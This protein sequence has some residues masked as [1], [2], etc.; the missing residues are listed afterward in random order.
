[1]ARTP[2]LIS[3]A[4]DPDHDADA[5]ASPEK[6]NDPNKADNESLYLDDRTTIEG[7]E[8]ADDA[9]KWV[10]TYDKLT[11]EQKV[12]VY[13]KLSDED[14]TELK[15]ADPNEGKQKADEA[16]A[17]K[18]EYDE[19][20]TDEKRK[21]AYDKLDADQKK[22]AYAA[23][24]ETLRKKLGIEDPAAVKPGE[25]QD[26]KLPDGVEMDKDSLGK[27]T[28]VFKSLTG[29]PTQ[30][31]A[32]TLIDIYT[33]NAQKFAQNMVKQQY[34]KY[35]ETRVSW[36]QQ[37]KDDAELGG[38]KFQSTMANVAK[39]RDFFLRDPAHRKDF[40]D[41][42]ELTGAGDHLAQIRFMNAVG[43]MIKD[44]KIIT[45][46]EDPPEREQDAAAVMFGQT[47]KDE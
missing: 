35:I 37:V 18:K 40:A 16:T 27:A 19:A 29:P 34:D 33:E 39:A 21:A 44:D 31:Q 17:R 13:A 30:E 25:Y 7:F 20:D 11:P 14:K 41:A 3:D 38:S 26:F 5:G 24:D 28:G 12:E 43:K 36:Q 6:L 47:M 45:S 10:A 32:Q 46:D 2:S 1:M 42:M 4:V 8:E 23:M 9:E 15:L 22:T